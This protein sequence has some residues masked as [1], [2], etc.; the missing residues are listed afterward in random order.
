[1][2]VDYAWLEYTNIYSSPCIILFSGTEIE[3]LGIQVVHQVPHIVVPHI[4]DAQHPDKVHRGL[5]LFSRL[6]LQQ[7][8]ATREKRESFCVVYH[9]SSNN[10]L[11]SLLRA[12]NELC[13]IFCQMLY[14]HTFIKFSAHIFCLCTYTISG[15]KI[16]F[17][18][19]K[20][21]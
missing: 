12:L 17:L 16:K 11:H 18:R 13:I 5:I 8:L 2:F 6:E 10:L 15:I 19:W 7:T 9:F 3:I 20:K 14:S 4:V 21:Q 1:M